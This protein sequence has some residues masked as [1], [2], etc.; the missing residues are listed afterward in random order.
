LVAIY[1][2]DFQVA[3]LQLAEELRHGGYWVCVS[4]MC[5]FSDEIR[6]SGGADMR[7]LVV[8][9]AAAMFAICN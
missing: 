3:A 9:E 1:L 4:L 5:F 7:E 2:E 8:G 6:Y